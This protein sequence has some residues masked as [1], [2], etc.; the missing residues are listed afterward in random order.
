[1]ES[2]TE[3]S[4]MDSVSYPSGEGNGFL[5]I[6]RIPEFESIQFG[7]FVCHQHAKSTRFKDSDN[8]HFKKK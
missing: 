1:M 3:H 4:E 7:T 5:H 2:E 8:T 6:N